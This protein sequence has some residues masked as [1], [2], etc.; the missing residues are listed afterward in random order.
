MSSLRLKFSVL[1]NKLEVLQ[2]LNNPT[3]ASLGSLQN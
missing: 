1:G 2:G 3:S